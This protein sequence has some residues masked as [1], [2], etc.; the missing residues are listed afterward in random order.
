MLINIQIDLIILKTYDQQF[1]LI[2]KQEGQ[3][4]LTGQRAANFRLS[5]L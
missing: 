4:L 5:F 2:T 3:H 1:T